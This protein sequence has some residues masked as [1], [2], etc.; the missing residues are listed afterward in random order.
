MTPRHPIEPE[1]VRRTSSGTYPVVIASL[2]A[3]HLYRNVPGGDREPV[4]ERTRGDRKPLHDRSCT[5]EDRVR[6][7]WDVASIHVD[8]CVKPL[9]PCDRR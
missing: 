4:P 8:T 3:G 5:A 7:S 2:C 6:A 9:R 1:I